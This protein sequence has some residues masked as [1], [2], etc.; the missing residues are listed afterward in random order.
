MQV[1]IHYIA[2]IYILYLR[3]CRDLD[4][5][6]KLPLNNSIAGCCVSS[7]ETINISNAYEDKRFN[8]TADSETGFKTKSIIAICLM[9]GAGEPI[10][11]LEAVNKRGPQQRFN[12]DDVMLLNTLAREIS[13][14]LRRQAMELAYE[15]HSLHNNNQSSKFIQSLLSQYS[16]LPTPYSANTNKS[17]ITK[18]LS[19]HCN[20]DIA[21]KFEV[22]F[23]FII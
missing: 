14:F 11:V 23:I 5:G 8:S 1:H 7:R 22:L 12:D 18:E 3:V 17:V 10:G 15:V 13:N 21:E 20:S 4:P 16:E 6:Y 9:D 19:C 2:S